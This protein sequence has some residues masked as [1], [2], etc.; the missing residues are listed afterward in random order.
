MNDA[1][2]E[3]KPAVEAKAET[4]PAAEAKPQQLTRKLLKPIRAHG[5]TYSELK[6]KEPTAEDLE[7]VGIPC[8]F[9]VGV[10]EIDIKHDQ[11]VWVQMMSNLAAVPPSSIRQMDPRDFASCIWMLQGF[12]LPVFSD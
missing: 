10:E 9:K 4:P 1:S 5:E 12:F 2:K 6:F 3:T 7:R 8:V 11:K